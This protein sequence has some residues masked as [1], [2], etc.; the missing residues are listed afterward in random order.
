VVVGS[1]ILNALGIRES[2][3][4]DLIVTDEIYTKF[5]AEGWEKDNWSDQV[6]LKHD[7]FDLGKSWYGKSI[8]ELSPNAQYIDNIPYLSLEDVYKWK[9]S[10]GRDKD[11]HD[12]EL[13]DEYKTRSNFVN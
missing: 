11:L 10:L 3:D 2:R 1:G 6:V 12:L 13:I 8:D 4:I 7:V 5:E 9:K